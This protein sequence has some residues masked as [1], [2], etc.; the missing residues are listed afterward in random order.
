M[1]LNHFENCFHNIANS[2]SKY[3][4]STSPMVLTNEE[5]QSLQQDPPITS[6]QVCADAPNRDSCVVINFNKAKIF[7]NT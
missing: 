5:C 4:L 1:L 6:S 7:Y 3:L 2:E